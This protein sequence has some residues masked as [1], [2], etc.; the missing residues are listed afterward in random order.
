MKVVVEHDEQSIKFSTIAI[1]L[2]FCKKLLKDKKLVFVDDDKGIPI[3]SWGLHCAKYNDLKVNKIDI[4]EKE[5]FVFGIDSI[6]IK[7]AEVE[8]G[9]LYAIK[10]STCVSFKGSPVSH[11][12]IGPFLFYLNEEILKNFQL[13]HNVL[14]LTLYNDDYAKK[15]LR[16][17]FERFIQFCL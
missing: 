16:I 1:Q 13:D 7:V 6:C 10:G 12:K 5:K 2:G 11:F 4:C 8:D 3:Q 9:G 14:K 17:N 15:F